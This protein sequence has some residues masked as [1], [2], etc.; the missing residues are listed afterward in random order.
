MLTVRPL[1]IYSAAFHQAPAMYQIR[2]QAPGLQPE[3]T[4]DKHP[5]PCGAISV[6]EILKENFT[7]KG[8]EPLDRHSR[9][10]KPSKESFWRKRL[11]LRFEISK[12]ESGDTDVLLRCKSR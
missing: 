1:F 8:E 10:A 9:T 5:C 6:G 3:Q 2:C 4:D 12:W 11:L 7:T